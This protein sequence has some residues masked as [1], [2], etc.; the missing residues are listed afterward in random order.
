MGYGRTGHIK[1]SRSELRKAV[2]LRYDF[3]RG[4]N[5]YWSVH[6]FCRVLDVH[7]SGFYAWLQR[8]HSR[9]HHTDLKLMGKS[10][11]FWLESGCVYG[12]HK[13]YMDFRDAGQQ[14]SVKKVWRLIGKCQD[15]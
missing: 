12:Y 4:N 2:Q 7:L 15:S 10:K 6:L 9:W 11:Q 13:I 5:H 8:P 3:I 14:C 1:K